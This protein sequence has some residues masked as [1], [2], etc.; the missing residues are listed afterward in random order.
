[1]VKK[2][3]SRKKNYT[4]NITLPY[5]VHASFRASRL[6]LSL[7]IT[8]THSA[9]NGFCSS[10]GSFKNALYLWNAIEPSIS[11]VRQIS[12]QI[13][14]NVAISVERSRVARPAWRATY[15]VPRISNGFS[16]KWTKRGRYASRS[17]P[18]RSSSRISAI[19]EQ[20]LGN[21]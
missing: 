16:N 19:T 8:L 15:A 13:R 14:K 11:T 17:P 7:P 5:L 3:N 2:Q 6:T 12:Q 1:M 20:A 18:L 21:Q 9:T 4:G 10:S